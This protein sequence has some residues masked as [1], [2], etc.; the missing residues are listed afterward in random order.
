MLL[1]AIDDEEKALEDL[2]E[3]IG[4]ALPDSEIVPF[5]RADKAL[6]AITDSP[7]KPDVVFSDIRMPGMDGLEL[8]VRI[9][10]L[11]QETRIVFVTAYSRYAMDAF[12]VH[13]NGYL[14]KPVQPE[15]ITEQMMHLNL[16][17]ENKHEKLDVRC[18][19]NFEVFWDGKPLA[20]KRRRTKELF[21]YLIDRN[22]AT[23]TAEEVIAVLWE[24]ESNIAN[25]KH[26]VRNLVTDLR[27]V[28]KSIRQEHVL[29]R[30]SGTLAIDRDA[31]DCDYY[32]MLDGDMTA[33]N[34]YR[35]EYMSQ[36]I[37]AQITEA[38]LHFNI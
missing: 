12:D 34:A 30:G 27:A 32:R 18:F 22:G 25:A 14:M 29:I 28:L 17:Y 13:A 36:Y 8:A 4:T 33:V 26:N 35:G 2:C 31:V 7:V 9:K 37:W 3:V 5:R 38:E 24:D 19:G 21:A 15:D 16:G 11:S 1:F 10:R 6:Q 23:C 20:F